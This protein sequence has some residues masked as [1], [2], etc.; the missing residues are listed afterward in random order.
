MVLGVVRV[1]NT[2][3]TA[4]VVEIIADIVG[5]R[6]KISSGYLRMAQSQ[7]DVDSR[8]HNCATAIK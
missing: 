1:G 4:D 3:G 6:E 8:N 5:R 2:A 7:T